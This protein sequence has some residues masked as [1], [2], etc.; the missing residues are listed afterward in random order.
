M[1]TKLS[2]TS[3]VVLALV[4]RLQAATA[5]DLKTLAHTTVLNF[6]ALPHTVI[7]TETRRLAAAGLL[8][9]DEEPG[10]R[11]RRRFSLTDAGRAA[12]DDWRA[13]PTDEFLELR[14]P[15][16]LRL[17]AGG[18]AKALAAAQLA[19]HQAQLDQ[20]RELAASWDDRAHPDDEATGPRSVLAAGL[21]ME[22]AYVRFWTTVAADGYAT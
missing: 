17:F 22:E 15:G 19:R 14:D 2:T 1:A 6:W 9:P 21:A 13:E 16:L 11:R 7:Y 4:E 10:G 18:E 20:Y 12:L 8:D 5:Y 3:Y